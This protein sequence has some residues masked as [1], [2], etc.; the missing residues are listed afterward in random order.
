[1]RQTPE[2]IIPQRQ[3]KDYFGMKPI[4]GYLGYTSGCCQTFIVNITRGRF[5]F[6]S[7]CLC[8]DYSVLEQIF[9]ALSDT[10][11]NLCLGGAAGGVSV[12]FFLVLFAML[13]D[14][15]RFGVEAAR[16]FTS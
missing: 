8:Q 7:L 13:T 9:V 4:K 16:V 6:S 11:R 1:M 15:Y 12:T 5:V 2:P 14:V 10:R 3:W